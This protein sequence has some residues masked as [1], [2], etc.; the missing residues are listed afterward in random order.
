[1]SAFNG[2]Y[3]YFYE[4]IFNLADNAVKYGNDG[5]FVKIIL[6]ET[7]A[8]RQIIVEDNGPGIP[9]EDQNRIFE[10]FYRVDK[11]HSR[12]SEGTGLGLS[13]VKR[14]ARFFGGKVSVV[15]AVGQGSCFKVVIPRS[16]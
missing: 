2:I 10:R 14:A 6:S 15:S 16:K 8:F 13:I 11:S 9:I 3:R 1:M 12:R 7:R 5:G 4:M